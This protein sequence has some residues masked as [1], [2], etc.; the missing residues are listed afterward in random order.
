[1]PKAVIYDMDGLL[2]DSEPY[3]RKSMIK[4]L[5]SVGLQLTEEQ[6]AS[7]TGLRF[8]H[9][10]EYWYE[11]YP[12]EAKTIVEVHEEILDDMEYAITHEAQLMPGVIE[13]LELFTSRGYK[14]A[15]AS[16]SAM[17]LIQACVKRL[18]AQEIFKAV[19]SAEHEEYGKPHPAVF[20]KAAAELKVHPLDCIVLEDSLMG[21]IAAKAA[22]MQCVAIPAPEN[23]DNPKFA[24]ADWRLRSLT[25]LASVLPA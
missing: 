12:W 3:W 14:V 8:D 11:K 2:I 15:L 9:V 19:I 1:M 16:S 18:H 22:R 25:E 4:V 20:I 6:C 10:L 23:F 24:I 7:T 13:S 21:V 17:R 5:A